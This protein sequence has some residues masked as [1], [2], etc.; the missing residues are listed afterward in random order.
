MPFSWG[1]FLASLAIALASAGITAL[2][3]VRWTR[4]RRYYQ[5]REW[6]RLRGLKLERAPTAPPPLPRPLDCLNPPMRLMWL[7]RGDADIDRDGAGDGQILLLRGQT[8]TVT[9]NLLI[10][11]LVARGHAVVDW[12]TSALRPVSR[13]TSVI[14]DLGLFSYP[15]TMGVARFTLHGEHPGVARRLNESPMRGLLPQDVGLIV[16]GDALILDFSDRPFDQLEFDRMMGLARQ[17]AAA[18]PALP[19][20]H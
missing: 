20:T 3:S 8:P 12:P 19:A 14:D 17:L 11:T 10:R 6:C 2:L 18:L 15:S 7:M 9:H 16:A 13:S 5:L 1:I 4:H